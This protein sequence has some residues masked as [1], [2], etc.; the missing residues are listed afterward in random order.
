MALLAIV[1]A[2]TSCDDQPSVAQ[3]SAALE[4]NIQVAGATNLQPMMEELNRRGMKATVWLSAQEMNDSC[5]YVGTL[6]S[7][8]HEIA[9]KYPGQ[10]EDSTSYEE[11]KTEIDGML[12]AS[13][14]CAGKAMTGFRATRFTANDDTFRLLDDLDVPYL[15]R[16]NR[17]VL[18]SIYTFL[19]YRLE[20]HEFSVLPMPLAVFYGETA[21]LCDTATAGKLTSAELLGYEKAS[22]DS[23]IKLGEPLVLE[24]HPEVTHPGSEA[25]WSTFVGTLDYI[26]SKGASVKVVTAESIVQRHPATQ[27][28][29][30]GS[31]E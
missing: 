5:T 17:Q 25:C 4:I 27:S 19:P 3:K 28:L 22:I 8:G 24:W 6:A 14:Q 26:E 1:A 9:G 29:S 16:S 20:G 13:T 2:A 10:I 18:L 23:H 12:A 21:S 11:Q 15:V 7:Q 30:A 31:E